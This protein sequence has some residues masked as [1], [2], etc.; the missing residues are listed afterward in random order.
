MDRPP[1]VNRSLFVDKPPLCRQATHHGQTIPRWTGHLGF[2]VHTC[3][4]AV[5]ARVC[6]RQRVPLALAETPHGGLLIDTVFID[7]VDMVLWGLQGPQLRAQV[8]VL[9]AI[10]G[11]GPSWKREQEDTKTQPIIQTEPVLSKTYLIAVCV[12]VCVAGDG[13]QKYWNLQKIKWTARNG[14]N[15]SS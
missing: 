14:S 9:A 2:W 12:C 3:A 1:S 15:G 10:W 13:G 4:C 11:P 5:R 7:G 6:W 8:A